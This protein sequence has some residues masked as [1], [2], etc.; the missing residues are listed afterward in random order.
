MSTTLPWHQSARVGASVRSPI[1][2]TIR[3][4]A[5]D[6]VQRTVERLNAF[7]PDSL[8]AYASVHRLLAREQI[9][10]TLRISPTA[11]ALAPDLRDEKLV[12]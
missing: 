2:P 1:V 9:A 5:T 11:A 3:I 8:I 12:S 7:Q 4:D 6:P 10:G